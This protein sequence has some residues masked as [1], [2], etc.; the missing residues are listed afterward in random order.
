MRSLQLLAVILSREL[1]PTELVCNTNLGAL[2]SILSAFSELTEKQ[3]RELVC[4]LFNWYESAVQEC[5]RFIK[6]TDIFVEP[7]QE[8]FF[9]LDASRAVRRK[10][11]K[12]KAIPTHCTDTI[13]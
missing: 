5:I 12:A 1:R 9:I 7:V 4:P 6:K 2:M 3:V 8:D 10:G 13:V 11:R